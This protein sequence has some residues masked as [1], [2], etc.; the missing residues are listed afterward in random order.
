MLGIL[1]FYLNRLVQPKIPLKRSGF[2]MWHT[3]DKMRISAFTVKTVLARVQLIIISRRNLDK[4]SALGTF[5]NVRSF[6]AG[7]LL[8]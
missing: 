2:A 5:I 7:I 3:S 8:E 1:L 4:W 6:G